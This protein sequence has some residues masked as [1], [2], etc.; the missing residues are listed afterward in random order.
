FDNLKLRVSYGKSGNSN[1][2]GAFQRFQALG[3]VFGSLG[4]GVRDVGVIN[5][6]LANDDLRWETTGQTDL[7]LE[8]GFLGGRLN[9][10][11]DFYK[12]ITNDLLFTKEIASQTGFINRLENTGSVENKGIDFGMNATLFDNNDFRWDMDINISTYENK[13]IEHGGE[14]L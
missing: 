7:G 4:R 10:E 14:D 6:T 12:S 2:I 11:I 13:I 1:G 5:N 9:F 3:T 8:M